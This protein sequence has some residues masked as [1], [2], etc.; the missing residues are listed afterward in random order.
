MTSRS[1]S[2]YHGNGSAAA[3]RCF[4]KKDKKKIG[5]AGVGG[6]G[7]SS[8]FQNDLEIQLILLPHQ[9]SGLLFRED[10]INLD[11]FFLF[12]LMRKL[13]LKQVLMESV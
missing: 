7:I 6:G 2:V 11:I 3:N 1:S 5:G 10:K 8:L 12:F 13:K 9:C 4:L